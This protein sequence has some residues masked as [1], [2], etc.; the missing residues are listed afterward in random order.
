MPLSAKNQFDFFET[1]IF[2]NPVF[3]ATKSSFFTNIKF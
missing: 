2:W 3:E 1:F